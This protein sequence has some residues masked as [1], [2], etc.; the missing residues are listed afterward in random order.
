MANLLF[1]YLKKN[2][3]IYSLI[4]G[5]GLILF[6]NALGINIWLPNCLVSQFTG[7][8]C[9]SCGINR[10]AIALISGDIQSAVIYNP[11]IFIYLPMIIGWII[12]DFYKF[13]LNTNQSSYEEH[14]WII[15]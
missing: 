10:A 8:E 15:N 2:W 4:G 12:Y 1:A 11:L 9:F 7:H 3:I 14:R 13:Y 5:Y 6:L